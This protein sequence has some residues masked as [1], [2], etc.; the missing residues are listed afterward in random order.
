[1][2]KVH[3]LEILSWT[4]AFTHKDNPSVLISNPHLF[5]WQQA[6]YGIYC[7]TALPSVLVSCCGKV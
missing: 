6:F 4:E 1:M 7:V 5:Q 3:R 2:D